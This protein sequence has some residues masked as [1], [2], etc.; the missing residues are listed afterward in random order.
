[1]TFNLSSTYTR[2]SDFTSIY[3][4]DSGLYWTKENISSH[5]KKDIY[6]L[7][8]AAYLAAAL[9]SKKSTHRQNYINELSKFMTIEIYGKMGTLQCPENISDCREFISIKYMFFLVFENSVCRDYVTEK[10][11]DTL[12]YDIIPVVLGDGNYNYYIPKSGFINALDF[13]SPADLATYLVALSNNKETYNKYFE[14]K[15]YIGYR[16]IP[17]VQAY[18]YHWKCV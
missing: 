12:K 1:V 6:S 9:I 10:F 8:N 3:W 7:K 15:K 11:F 18:L 14:W 13:E 5:V 17:V 2:E 4:T 16:K